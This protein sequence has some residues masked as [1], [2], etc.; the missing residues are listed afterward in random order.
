[1]KIFTAINNEKG[2]VLLAGL[3]FLALLSILGATAYLLS[4]TD[5]AISANYKYKERAFNDAEAGIQYAK[6]AIQRMLRDGS[7]LPD[8]GGAALPITDYGDVPEVFNFELSDIENIGYNRCKFTSIG[9]GPKGATAKIVAIITRESSSRYAVFGVN[10]VDLKKSTGVFSYHSGDSKSDP[11]WGRASPAE[12]PSDDGFW[13]ADLP[14]ASGDDLHFS[15]HGASV[16]SNGS[17]D[18][19]EDVL[20]AMGAHIDGTLYTGGTYDPK[21]EP[22]IKNNGGSYGQEVDIPPIVADPET[23]LKDSNSDGLTDFYDAFDYYKFDN[24]NSS[25]LVQNLAAGQ[26]LNDYM[27][28]NN[29]A[30]TGAG[31]KLGSSGGTTNYYFE[32]STGDAILLN[33]PLTIDASNGD[34]DIWVRGRLVADCGNDINV[35]GN[36]HVNIYVTEPSGGIGPATIVDLKEGSDLNPDGPVSQLNLKTD[37]DEIVSISEGNHTKVVIYAPAAD[38]DLDNSAGFAG[39]ILGSTVTLKNGTKVYFDEALKEKNLSD[40]IRIASW[41]QILD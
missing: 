27:I 35:T 1:M 16:F 33:Q 41:M 31:L 20:I 15:T 8:Q 23:I 2:I 40:V 38:I 17:G 13:D 25:G 4:T 28:G 26:D 32:D 12:W 29:E 11:V 36:H 3:M 34:V 24:S 22:D 6:Y 5:M 14:G 19:N 30:A 37:S 10:Q 39:S 9:H 7:D 18:G 21:E